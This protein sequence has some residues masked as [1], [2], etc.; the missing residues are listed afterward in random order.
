MVRKDAGYTTKGDLYKRPG[1]GSR[2]VVKW[3][4]IP[5][6]A[7]PIVN[8]FTYENRLQTQTHWG[9]V[10]EKTRIEN[11]VFEYPSVP[12]GWR[13]TSILTNG[14]S[15][16]KADKYLQYLNGHL[17]TTN[18]GYKKVRIW[19]LVY[20]GRMQ[21]SAELQRSYWKGGNKNEIIIMIGTD[22]EQNIAW[23]DIM[24]QAD[25]SDALM[26]QIRDTIL[27]QM[28]KKGDT[29]SGKLTDDDLLKFV[30]WLGP[31]VKAGYTKPDFK[32]YAYIQVQ[33]SL[34]AILISYA[35]ILI[36]NIGTGI[37]V[38]KNPWHDAGR[39]IS[40]RGGYRYR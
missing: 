1:Y 24:T 22:K 35:I 27:L 2:H 25:E 11:D 30:Q 6:T 28:T 14:P 23:T 15:F 26:I 19:L 3:D 17:N 33:P 31:S 20:S 16:R 21:E 38:V 29:F 13:L 32:Q 5:A 18:G 8:E 39:S 40:R 37:F 7:E 12:A 36:V 34:F 9:K 4:K 10:D